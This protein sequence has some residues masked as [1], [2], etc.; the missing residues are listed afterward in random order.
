MLR[1][2]VYWASVLAVS[3]LCTEPIVAGKQ[4]DRKSLLMQMTF[5]SDDAWSRI[6]RSVRS[7]WQCLSGDWILQELIVDVGRYVVRT[8]Y[9]GRMI[10]RSVVFTHRY[11]TIPR[12]P[13][14][15]RVR[16]S[17]MT[18]VALC[19]VTRKYPRGST[20]GVLQG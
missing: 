9:E 18:K 13:E 3:R 11:G 10:S 2:E 6:V 8:P 4:S 19:R 16:L 20:R 7:S 5:G 15:R 12:F 14:D 1:A 17:T